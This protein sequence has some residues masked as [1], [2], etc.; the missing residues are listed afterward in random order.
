MYNR[1]QGEK[2]PQPEKE[3]AQDRTSVS[4]GTCLGK[5][6]MKRRFDLGYQRHKTGKPLFSGTHEKSGAQRGSFKKKGEFLGKA[7]EKIVK[8]NGL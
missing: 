3:E 1:S 5:V 2:T 8:K 6:G 7:E 4:R